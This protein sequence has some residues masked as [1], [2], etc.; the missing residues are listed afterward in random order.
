[1]GINFYI[2]CASIKI[3]FIWPLTALIPSTYHKLQLNNHKPITQFYITNLLAIH[4]QQDLFVVSCCF[5]IYVNRHEGF[6]LNMIK[7][8]N[9][10]GW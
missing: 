4:T 5:T 10:V 7:I 9:L 1:M 3:L 2:T 6:S 8:Q